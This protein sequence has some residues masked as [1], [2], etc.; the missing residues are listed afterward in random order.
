MMTERWS[1]STILRFELA[2]QML[3]DVRKGIVKRIG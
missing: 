2:A 3:V 1:R